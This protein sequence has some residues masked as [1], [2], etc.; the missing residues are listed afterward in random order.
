MEPWGAYV[1]GIF[2][3]IA[4]I[5]TRDILEKL[6]SILFLSNILYL[7]TNFLKLVDDPT[8]GI[9]IYFGGGFT[10]LLTSPFLISD[11]ILIKAD[12]HASAV[13]FIIK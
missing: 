6:K 2:G 10:G 3:A 9:A 4:F 7:K 1:T 12:H 11:G 13:V 8:H 5:T